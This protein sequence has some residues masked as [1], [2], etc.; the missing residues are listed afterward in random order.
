VAWQSHVTN[1]EKIAAALIDISPL[2]KY[3]IKG[4][5]AARLLN[6]VVTRDIDRL[7]V[8]QVYY[9]CW[10]ATLPKNFGTM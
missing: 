2:M 7:Q 3:L 5:D 4:K 8:G 9:T 1:K 10:C 6:R